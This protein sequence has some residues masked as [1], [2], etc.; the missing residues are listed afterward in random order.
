MRT[1]FGK[2]LYLLLFAALTSGC[3]S[4]II[5]D[6]KM[7]IEGGKKIERERIPGAMFGVSG[8]V[9]EAFQSYHPTNSNISYVQIDRNKCWNIGLASPFIPIPIIP[10]FKFPNNFQAHIGF[11]YSLKEEERQEY[12]KDLEA[13]LIVDNVNYKGE[14]RDERT[15]SSGSTYTAYFEFEIKCTDIGK[16]KII[17]KDKS[18]KYSF[19]FFRDSAFYYMW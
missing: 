2:L 9:Y 10:I 16:G 11:G 18:N 12:I 19:N 7:I 8:K 5:I 6:N 1:L 4:K 17:I 14:Y 15:N 13:I 3:A